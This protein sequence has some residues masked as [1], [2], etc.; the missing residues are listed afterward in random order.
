MYDIKEYITNAFLT[1]DILVMIFVM[2]LFLWHIFKYCHY[3]VGVVMD[4]FKLS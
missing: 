4:L 2:H 3:I 1:L